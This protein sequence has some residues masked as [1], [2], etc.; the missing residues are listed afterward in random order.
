MFL[1]HSMLAFA[2]SLDRAGLCVVIGLGCYALAAWTAFLV[3]L[4]GNRKC[5]LQNSI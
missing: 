1:T 5:S 4:K 3:A 2:T